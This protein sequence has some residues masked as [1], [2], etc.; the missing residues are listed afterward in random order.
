VLYDTYTHGAFTEGTSLSERKKAEALK[1]MIRIGWGRHNAAY[2]KVFANLFIPEG[3]E[4]QKSWL[5]QLQRQSATTETAARLWRGFHEIDI[6]DL[7]PQVQAPTLVF[8][9]E[10]DAMVPFQEGCRLASLIPDARFVPLDGDNHI[11]LPDEPAWDRF[12]AELHAF[13]A[14]E[15][16]PVTEDDGFG[17]LTPREREVLDLMARGISNA[18]IAE[19]LYISPKTV[20]NHITR[21]F[22]KLRVSR[23]AEAI[24]QAREAGFGR[25]GTP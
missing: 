13:L 22:R 23:R 5:A 8:H 20:R 3:S 7:A 12:V 4:E 10:N 25:N 17:E 19:R 21:I 14:E 1:D 2:R 16:R 15:G 6:R 11:L 24:V 18:D 9:V